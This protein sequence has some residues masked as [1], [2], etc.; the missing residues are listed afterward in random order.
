M[1][2]PLPWLKPS[3]SA[4]SAQYSQLFPPNNEDLVGPEYKLENYVI[5]FY[6]GSL[7]PS[8]LK[9][10]TSHRAIVSAVKTSGVY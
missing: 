4:D 10:M 6:E 1:Q 9:S 3:T 7:Y 8:P 2:I 5:V